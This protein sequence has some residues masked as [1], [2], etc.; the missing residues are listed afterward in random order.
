MIAIE[1]VDLRGYGAMPMN[2]WG[3]STLLL[4]L[5]ERE[6]MLPE[7]H[8]YGVDDGSYCINGTPVGTTEEEVTSNIWKMVACWQKNGWIAE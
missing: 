6:G 7:C 3:K 2:I 1:K 4:G 8:I 5:L